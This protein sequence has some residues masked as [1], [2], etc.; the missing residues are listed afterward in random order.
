MTCGLE[1]RDREWSETRSLSM[2][3]GFVR[4]VR[5]LDFNVRESYRGILSK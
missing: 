3:I 2:Q 1:G 4:E 5:S